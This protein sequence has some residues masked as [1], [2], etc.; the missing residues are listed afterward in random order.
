MIKHHP[1]LRQLR[2]LWILTVL[3]TVL[4]L[5][6]SA[7]AQNSSATDGSTPAGL[8]PGAPAGSYGLSGFDNVNLYN[9]N[10]NFRLPLVSIGGRGGAG[11]TMLLPIE[12][13]WTMDH[14]GPDADG[15]QSDTPND[16][17][18]EVIR[19]GYFPGVLQ[20]RNVGW[21]AGACDRGSHTDYVYSQTF[22]RLTFTAADGTEY[23][24]VDVDNQGSPHF[25][26]CSTTPYSRG[27]VFVSH[28]GSSATFI[29]D[30]NVHDP[31]V[32]EGLHAIASWADTDLNGYLFLRDGTRYRITNG[33][34]TEIRDRNGNTITFTSNATFDLIITDSLNRQ[35]TVNYNYADAAPYGLC[36]RIIFKG[37]GGATRIIRVSKNSHGKPTA[38]WLPNDDGLN[39][40]YSFYY[41]THWELSRVDLPTGGAFEYDWGPGLTGSSNLEGWFINNNNRYEIYRR[42][43]EK[44][45]YSDGTTLEGKTI[46]TS[47]ESCGTDPNCAG[48][49]SSG[50]ATVDEKDANGNLLARQRHYFNGYGAA[51]SIM[52]HVGISPLVDDLEGRE[53][54]TRSYAANGTTLLRKMANTWIAASVF[55]QGPLLTQVESTL[56]DTNQVSKQTFAYD[57]YGNRT[58]SYE[59]D[60]GAGAAGS[61]IRHSRTSYLTTNDVNGA[62]YDTVNWSGSSPSVSATI[63]TRS[64]PTQTSVFDAT[65][66]PEIERAR[67]T[68]EYDKYSG[69]ANH[70]GLK[71]WATITGYSTSGLD[72]AYTTSMTTRGNVT[73]TTRYLL[74]SSGSVTGSISGYAQYD[75]AGNVWKA[76]DGRGN[77]TTF[78]FSDCFGAPDGN[79]TTSTAPAELSSASKYSY[80]FA[81][82]VTN[83][84]NQTAYVQFD[85]YLGKPVDGQDLNGVVSSGF[86]D[87]LLDRPTKIIRDYNN[88]AAKSQTVFSYDDA[89]RIVTTTSDFDHFG[90][91]ALT[92]KVF[93]DGLGRT[94]ESRQ[95]EDPTHYIAVRAQY[96]AL[97]RA[98]KTSNPFRPLSPNNESAV[99]TTSAFDALGRI[100]SVTTPDSAVVTSSYSGNTV[101][102]TDQTLKSRKSVS[103]ALGRLTK[104]YEDP[105]GLN[106]L[107]SYT[108]DTLDNLVGVSQVDPVTNF[109]QTRTFV[110]DSLKRLMSASN[111]EMVNPQGVQ[112]PV[113]YQYDNNGNLT[114]KTDARGVVTTFAPYDALNRP[115]SKSYSDGTPSVGY[116]YDSQTLPD[117]K[118]TYTR[119]AS[120]GKLVAISYG[121][122][123][124]GDFYGFDAIGRAVLKIQQTG[125]VNYQTSASYNVSGALRSETYP[126][127]HSVTNTFDTAG[128]TSNVTGTLGDGS[129]RTYSTGI[130]YSS[131]GGMSK[132]QFGTATPIF[133]KLFY[134]VRGQL[135][136]IR[137]GTSYTGPSDTGWQ[138]G[139]II[140]FYDTC[141]GMCG[142]QNSTTQ[143][144]NNNGNLKT[145]A[146]FVPNDDAA[147][148]EDRASTFVQGFDYD[149]LNRLRSVQ[150]GSWRQWFDYDRYGNRTIN[151]NNT[152]GTG[153]PEPWYGVDVTTNRLTPP[154]GAMMQYDNAGNL[155]YDT[156]NGSQGYRNYDAENHMTQAWANG[157]WQTYAYDGTGQ[158]VKRMVGGAGE[159]WQVYGLWGEL[160]AEYSPSGTLQKEYGYRNRQLLITA[161][162]NSGGWGTPP[163]FQDN[164]LVVGQTTIRSVHITEL[165]SAIDSVRAHVGLS[166]YSW[167]TAAAPGDPI[168]IAP[169]QEMR[170][171][172]DQ[173]LGAG[174]YAGGLASGQAILKV[175]IQELRDRI[176]SAW[177]GGGGGVDIRWLV[178]DQLGTPRMIFDQSGSL[179]NVSR[180]DYLPFGED[181]AGVG[182]R[183]G[184]GYAATDGARQRFTGYEADSETNLNF[185]QARYQ[186]AGQGRFI[187]ADDFGGRL[188]NPQSINRYVYVLNNPLKYIDPT[189]HQDQKGKVEQPKPSTVFDD[190]GRRYHMT[191][192]IRELGLVDDTA[193]SLSNMSALVG[194]PAPLPGPV[195]KPAPTPTPMPP[196]YRS[197]SSAN[198]TQ[199][200]AFAV[201]G[202][203][204][205]I[206]GGPEDP[207]ADAIAGGVLTAEEIDILL[208][209]SAAT[210][211]NVSEA[212]RDK[213]EEERGIPLYRGVPPD[214]PGF[215]FALEGT[216]IP[217]GGHDNPI[218]HNAGDT[219][220]IFTSWTTNPAIAERFAGPGGVVLFKNIPPSR[221]VPSPD[222]FGEQEVLVVGPVTGARVIRIP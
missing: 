37:Y 84:L 29:S 13:H 168:S 215:L 68:F 103:D 174:S 10:L 20:K 192:S 170:T 78:G 198:M 161:T 182:G 87:D 94:S 32:G 21:I 122:G 80:A 60:F 141:W 47:P 201:A 5:C 51:N 74:N 121:G 221:T 190:K 52:N 6:A 115:T 156:S 108:Y 206:G 114:Q 4:F 31:L 153:I 3:M 184:M 79:A 120:I 116:F 15:F 97:G 90:D 112:V 95:Y 159:T 18:W 140:N 149:A 7:N 118:P 54:E 138:R 38:V 42:V 144:P 216:A 126:S 41:N 82:S 19:P 85:Y 46:F 211:A 145:Q 17:W 24:L 162:V 171:A 30:Q 214:H 129:S 16:D 43:L 58:D 56:S 208:L 204:I 44:R 163:S 179:A 167:Q 137:E 72:S 49:T 45:V 76:I 177:Q 93:Y 113:S 33:Y 213:S 119:G 139:A 25:N 39:R 75:I 9:G 124:A 142:G 180:H 106:Y 189:G 83:A 148:Y 100:V 197:N 36:D 181:L 150:E 81:T 62:A 165:R 86:Y 70:A 195:P 135:A 196:G 92:S 34:V 111:P 127:G 134:N 35:I 199:G 28:D 99:W 14:Y 104:V 183:V 220:S 154:G 12:Q 130:L 178:A 73:A 218:A 132:E 11:Y 157:S 166:A 169:I 57:N 101:T 8:K 147:G 191:V 1:Q 176:L 64:L 219:N 160:V 107:T 102:A 128:R 40:H 110:Y 164:P 69:D 152:Y 109:N 22:A 210:A 66:S 209:A 200:Q 155:T 98:Y 23:E 207:F 27:K 55:G 203:I 71:D 117:G 53:T 63:H 105:S 187:S 125:G 202:A 48:F 185:A 123:S 133:N 59:Y 212:A 2:P 88:L 89:N 96:D 151:Q 65:V 222:R 173:A 131:L 146:I 67:T 61:L 91:S 158:R 186:S 77:A 50:Y 136:E 143:M 26:G 217:I 188:T 205:V 194:G 175:H 193:N 172:L